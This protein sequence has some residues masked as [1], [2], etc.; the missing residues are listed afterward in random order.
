VITGTAVVVTIT[1]SLVLAATITASGHV[2]LSCIAVWVAYA[3]GASNLSPR[4]QTL[5][6][7]L[8]A[9]FLLA[10]VR[11]EYRKDM[12]LLWVLPVVTAV[13][14]NLHGS[15]FTGWVLLGCVAVGR[16]VQ[17]RSIRAAAPYVVTLGACVVAG[18]VNPYGP[19]AFFYLAS[20]GSNPVIRDFVTEW[21]P[22]TVSWREGIMFFASAVVLGGLALKARLRLSA[23]E[24]VTLLVFGYL[25]WSS[26]RAIVWWGLIIGPTLARL[27]GSVAPSREPKARDHPRVNAVIIAG[28]AAIA[29][30]ALPWTKAVLPILPA[31]KLGLFTDDTPVQVGAYLRSHDPPP[32]GKM[33][34]NQGW[35]G[36]LE[37]AAW[38]RHQ[39]F[40][41]GRIELHPPQVWFDYLDVVFPSA[42]WRAL[43]EQYDVS[44]LV[45]SKVE[46]KELIADLGSDPAWRLDYEDDQAVVFTRMQ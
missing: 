9:V 15:F 33:L 20:I 46:Q 26:V 35:G 32:G 37:W 2:R 22:A 17:E 25:A 1:F 19:G 36:Y 24:V 28:I 45:L 11:A 18:L 27:L 12:R 3:L 7:P 42:R 5:G 6:Y 29:L 34:N 43:L 23:V 8:F 40:L 41:D 14:A 10:V 21:A 30:A 44:Y 38:P 16:F 4:P 31:E 39:V 13:W